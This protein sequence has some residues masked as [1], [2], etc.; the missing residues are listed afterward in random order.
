MPTCMKLI[1]EYA[2]LETKFARNFYH[3]D[4]PDRIR[5][6][7]GE[8]RFLLTAAHSSNRMIDGRPRP[9]DRFTGA[10]AQLVATRAGQSWLA[11]DGVVSEWAVWDERIDRFKVALDAHLDAG[12]FVIDLRAAPPRV[13]GDIFISFGTDPS[14]EAMETAELIGDAFSDFKVVASGRLITMGQV[15]LRAYARSRGGDGIQLNISSAL[16]DPTEHP[17]TATEFIS[18]FSRMLKERSDALAPVLAGKIQK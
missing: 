2:R 3:G 9:A 17:V 7:A 5:Q 18:R 11:A 13:A 10:M 14:E 16:R 4:L 15:P 6:K 1:E 12:R 8:G